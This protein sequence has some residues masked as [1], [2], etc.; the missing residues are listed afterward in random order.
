MGNQAVPLLSAVIVSLGL[1]GFFLKSR[2]QK[3]EEEK[4]LNAFI[5]EFEVQP[6]PNPPP[7]LAP[8]PLTGLKF[9]AKDM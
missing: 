5:E 7:P 8:L 9:A 4:E 3:K 1:L 2:K 6:S